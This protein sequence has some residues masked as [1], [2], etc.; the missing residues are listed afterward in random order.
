MALALA[1]GV[2]GSA[3]AQSPKFYPDDPLIR[4]PDP[5]ATIDAQARQLSELLETVNSTFTPPGELHPE[6]GVIP[7]L[8]VNTLGEVMDG[9]WFVNRHATRRLTREELV[10]GPGNADPP[11]LSDPLQVLVVKPAGLRPGLLV[12]DARNVYLLR[13]DPPG[14]EELATGAEMVASRFFY[15]LGYHVGENYIVR[16]NRSAARRVGGRAGRVRCRTH[17][18]PDRARH[19]PVSPHRGGGARAHV[20]GRRHTS[21]EG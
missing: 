17:A 12:A 20:S 10:R 14:F 2:A 18:C 15:A 9:A 6:G 4:E 7:A 3:L 19:R 1:L 13:F 16:L 21:P 11:L 8:G 5:V